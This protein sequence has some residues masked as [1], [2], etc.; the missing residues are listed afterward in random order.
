MKPTDFPV[1]EKIIPL[2]ELLRAR[3]PE[4]H[5]GF[6]AAAPTAP[7]PAPIEIGAIAEPV[8]DDSD[9]APDFPLGHPLLD[10]LD[11][12]RGLGPGSCVEI[13][14]RTSEGVGTLIAGL[15]LGA[16]TSGRRYPLALIDGADAFD[17]VSMSDA[18]SS[19]ALCR[20]LLWVR[21]RHRI[22]HALKTADL[23]LRD[24]NLPVVLLD[25]QLCR[26]AD[27]RRDIPG[28][29]N[30]WYRL[31]SL[32]EKTGTLLLAFTPEP[33]IPAVPWR[34][35]LEHRW[36][37]TAIDRLPD[38]GDLLSELPRHRISRARPSRDE[39]ASP[40]YAAAG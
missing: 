36:P 21:C 25:L 6:P 29:P 40:L 23:L 1:S 34:L 30:T 33:I 9:R 7:T 4:A 24:G 14:A 11:E 15:I 19:S 5:R 38:T 2:R 35:E 37:L 13:V 12:G 10:Q 20:H 31:R 18:P 26:P 28:G 3:F 8:R 17:S 27:L 16:A 22:D 39:A 32:A